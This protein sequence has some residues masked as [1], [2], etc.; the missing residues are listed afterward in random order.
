M[1]SVRY[2][3]LL[4]SLVDKFIPKKVSNLCIV[5]KSYPIVGSNI[6]VFYSLPLYVENTPY[7]YV[8]FTSVCI[9]CHSIPCTCARLRTCVPVLHARAP[10][11]RYS[12]YF[13]DLTRDSPACFAEIYVFIHDAWTRARARTND[14]AISVRRLTNRS[15]RWFRAWPLIRN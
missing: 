13:V 3:N 14:R 1:Y 6:S 9:V 5:R 15:A 12:N 2:I 7:T 4:I 11:A 10:V 8:C